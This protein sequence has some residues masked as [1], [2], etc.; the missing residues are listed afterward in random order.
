[1]PLFDQ[2]DEVGDLEMSESGFNGN[3]HSNGGFK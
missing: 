3:L 2:I 1:M